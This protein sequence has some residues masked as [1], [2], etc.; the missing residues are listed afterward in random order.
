MQVGKEKFSITHDDDSV[1]G[2]ED[3]FEGNL[4]T[5]E[6]VLTSFDRCYGRLIDQVATAEEERD[7]AIRG[8]DL[9][10]EELRLL[11]E[12]KDQQSTGRSQQI[13]NMFSDSVVGKLQ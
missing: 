8:R 3:K 10:M 12:E 4:N 9:A 11:K 7:E 2:S 5:V 13:R 6:N 1:T